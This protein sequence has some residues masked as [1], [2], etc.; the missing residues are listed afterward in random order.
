MLYTSNTGER[1]TFLIFIILVNK[2]NDKNY[3]NLDYKNYHIKTPWTGMPT[4]PG[5]KMPWVQVWWHF[6][7]A[8]C[9]RVQLLTMSWRM[10]KCKRTLSESTRIKY[11]KAANTCTKTKLYT[12]TSKVNAFHS[13]LVATS[14]VNQYS[15]RVIFIAWLIERFSFLWGYR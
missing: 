9:Y 8:S 3:W 2:V 4:F 10:E 11:W 14:R 7:C 12:G 6:I 5:G 15:R 1:W 13:I